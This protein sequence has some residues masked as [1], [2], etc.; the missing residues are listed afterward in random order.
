MTRIVGGQA[1]GRR[2]VV[3][4]GQGTRPTSDRAREGLFNTLC[5]RLGAAGW[6]GRRVLDLYAG[7]GALGLEALSRGAAQAVLVESSPRALRAI[8]A[9]VEAVGLP[10]A[11]VHSTSVAEFLAGPATIADVVL[12]DPPYALAMHTLHGQVA[13]LVQHGWLAPD[14]W[15][16]V[17][18]SSRDQPWVWPQGVAAQASKTYGE[19]TLWFASRDLPTPSSPLPPLQGPQEP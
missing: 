13:T 2:L 4:A 3:P 15:V 9:N 16:V 14:A 12:L 5:S 1:R 11:Q 8:Q 6:Q 17:E 19:A 10:G 18:R 7:S